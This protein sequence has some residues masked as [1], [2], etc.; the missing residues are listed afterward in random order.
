MAV[1]PIRDCVFILQNGSRI[2]IAKRTYRSI[3]DVLTIL[4]FTLYTM[5]KTPRTIEPTLD[6][7]TGYMKVYVNDDLSYFVHEMV[8]QTFVPN[9]DNKPNI[10]HIDGNKMNNA[11]TNLEWVD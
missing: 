8:A 7:E 6:V 2:E 1:L 9:P 3:L 10:K 5:L 4:H 11:A